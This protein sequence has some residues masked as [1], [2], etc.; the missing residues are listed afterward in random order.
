[1]RQPTAQTWKILDLARRA[2]ERHGTT[3][4]VILALAIEAMVKASGEEM[5]EAVAESPGG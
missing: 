1:M 2:A 3:T 5:P 4:E